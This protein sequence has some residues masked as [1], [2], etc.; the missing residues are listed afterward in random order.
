MAQTMTYATLFA[1]IEGL[2]G[3]TFGT[4]EAARVKGL[5]NNRAWAAYRETDYWENMLVIGEERA[6]ND[7]TRVIPYTGAVYDTTLGVTDGNPYTATVDTFLRAHEKAPWNSDSVKEY[8]L[9]GGPDGARIINYTAKYGLETDLVGMTANAGAVTVTVSGHVDAY[10]GG[11]VQIDGVSTATV[12]INGIQT[13]TSV[14]YAAANAVIGFTITDTDYYS[15]FLNGTENIKV[16]VAFCT[17]KKRLTDTYGDDTGETTTVP[18]E[19]AQYI[20][21]GVMADMLRNDQQFE[22]AALEE[23]FAEKKLQIE[24]ERLERMHT[25]QIIGNR[26]RTHGSTQ[27]RFTTNYHG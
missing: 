8:E 21:H 26:I 12:D 9:A 10:V 7:L 22:A 6:V 25:T 27:G 14:S 15:A 20:I 11:T 13:V 23:N 17:Y 1:R 19:W 4:V 5:I 3:E 2:K 24:L 16:P 18:A